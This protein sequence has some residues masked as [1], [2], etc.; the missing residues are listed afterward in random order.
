MQILLEHNLITK[1]Q[2]DLAAQLKTEIGGTIG[3]HLIVIGAIGNNELA[4]FLEQ[5]CSMPQW[6]RAQIQNIDE[7]VLSL[8][9]A[10]FANELR[11]LPLALTEERL[12]LGITDPTKNDVIE[13]IAFNS[14]CV[15]EPV[16]VSEDNMTWG[17]RQY[18]GISAM[19]LGQEQPGLLDTPDPPQ[20]MET[21][22][23]TPE[24]RSE[25]RRS[26]SAPPTQQKTSNVPPELYSRSVSDT[27]RV[28]MHTPIKV[29]KAESV[30]PGG[31]LIP[32]PVHGRKSDGQLG[33]GTLLAAIHKAP[34]RNAIIDFA[35][36]YIMLFS[37]KAAFFI[38]KKDKI[39]GFEIVGKQTSR[40]AIRSYWVPL[41]SSCTLS[42]VVQDKSIHLGPLG[43]SPADAILSAAL[44]G[45][46][47]RILSIPVVIGDRV[48]GILYGDR[49]KSNIPPWNSLKRLGDV[50]AVNLARVLVKKSSK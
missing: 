45:R 38:V 42:R 1:E 17:L 20:A 16:L 33:E 8:V 3:Y 10:E 48:V 9:S 32:N 11:V 27:P 37:E 14:G 36:Q 24:R 28:Q 15:I 50:T 26:L 13:E 6:R 39:E 21:P 2:L 23:V 49:L 47:D 4:D 18:Y 12:T 46:P 22:E 5:T 40:T 31:P 44:G 43:R 41:K 34:S 7:K 19:T 29:T 30:A 25:N 35:L